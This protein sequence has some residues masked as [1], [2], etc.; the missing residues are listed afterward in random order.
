MI[1]LLVL[2]IKISGWL[3]KVNW[4]IFFILKTEEEENGGNVM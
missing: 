1:T 4:C 3:E 2:R